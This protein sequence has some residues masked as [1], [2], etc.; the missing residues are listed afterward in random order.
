MVEQG[1]E[2]RLENVLSLRKKMD[3]SEINVEMMKIGKWVNDNGLKKAGPIVTAT[4]GVENVD[5][6]QILDMEILVPIDRAAESS[7][8]YRF[9]EVFHLVNAIYAQH[10]GNPALLQNTYNKMV[11][12]LQDNRLQQITAAYN[13][14]VSELQPGQSLDEVIVDVYIGVNPSIL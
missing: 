14:N 4:F 2:L 12:Y 6:Q 5:N 8:E 1:R 7:G 11:A 3:R 13:V 9:K 10:K